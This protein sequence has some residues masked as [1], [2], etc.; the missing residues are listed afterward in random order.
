[1]YLELINDNHKGDVESMLYLLAI[2]FPPL[3]VLLAGKPFQALISVLLTICFWVPGVIHAILV[4][5]ESK[6]D[7][8]M[9]KQVELM[10]SSK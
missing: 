4:V 8:R 3:A 5:N 7:K 9:K 6:A 1:M 10:K 2:L